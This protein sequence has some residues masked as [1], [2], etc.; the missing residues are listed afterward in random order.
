MNLLGSL[1]GVIAMLIANSYGLPA[2]LVR[3]V[4]FGDFAVLRSAAERMTT[5]IVFSVVCTIVLAWWPISP[6][7][8][9]SIHPINW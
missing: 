3:A 6:L 1:L 7:W 9:R 4:L 5:G 2:G 8:S